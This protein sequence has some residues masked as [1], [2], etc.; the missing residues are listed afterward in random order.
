M[1]CACNVDGY[2]VSTKIVCQWL[3]RSNKVIL[4]P[5][6]K[7]FDI[8]GNSP[9]KSTNLWMKQIW[10]LKT[11]RIGSSPPT[12][13]FRWI[14]GLLTYP[15]LKYGGRKEGMLTTWGMWS[16]LNQG[17]SSGSW[18]FMSR[19]RWRWVKASNPVAS[20]KCLTW[21]PL[22]SHKNSHVMLLVPQKIR[23]CF[24][25]LHQPS[26]FVILFRTTFL[27]T[28]MMKDPTDLETII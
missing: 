27:N 15:D 12:L 5:F 21:Q 26:Q 10:R 19:I 20:K 28:S 11:R 17:H 7:L 1:Q 25:R 3:S 14:G 22:K 6:P 16:R 24:L 2:S 8:I 4:Q 23:Y 18:V 9:Y 13:I